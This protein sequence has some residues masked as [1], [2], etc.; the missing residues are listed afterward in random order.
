M[1]MPPPGSNHQ[2][3][4][5]GESINLSHR[6]A[7]WA[8]VTI[9]ETRSYVSLCCPM[10]KD[11]WSFPVRVSMQI[12]TGRKI[13]CTVY[14]NGSNVPSHANRLVLRHNLGEGKQKLSLVDAAG[15]P[16]AEAELTEE[17]RL[18]DLSGR[19]R[20]RVTSEWSLGG[21]HFILRALDEAGQPAT[22]Q[23]VLKV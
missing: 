20:V 3:P 15:A 22:G 19:E 21:R 16:W 13:A 7:V 10:P 18:F 17:L 23:Q 11:P 12:E 6:G 1:A 8:H 2:P 5:A 4:S 9:D 14:A